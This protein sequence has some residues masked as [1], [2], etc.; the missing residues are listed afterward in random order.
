MN[1]KYIKD[2]RLVSKKLK[3]IV[4]LDN[5][6][7]SGLIQPDNLLL[8]KTFRSE[9]E[10]NQ[11]SNLED[12]LIYLAKL[13]DVRSVKTHKDRFFRKIFNKENKKPTLEHNPPILKKN[14]SS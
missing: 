6:P 7:N 14:N 11:L 13:D 10:D 3:N 4:L 2:L 5:N 1:K 12:F 8:I 9:Q